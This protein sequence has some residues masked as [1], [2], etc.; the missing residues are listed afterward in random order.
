M[1]DSDDSDDVVNLLNSQ[2]GPSELHLSDDDDL[3]DDDIPPH[4]AG[5]SSSSAPARR[6]VID[7]SS[8]EDTDDDADFGV[9]P[10]DILKKSSGVSPVKKHFPGEESQG[11]GEVGTTP[12]VVP[13]SDALDVTDP[14]VM[15]NSDVVE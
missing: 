1:D 7:D 10:L 9:R 6:D 8:D 15:T 11:N 12:V 14:S 3:D 4:G 5:E 13:L 2:I